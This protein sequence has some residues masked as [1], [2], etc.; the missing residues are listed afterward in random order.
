[1]YPLVSGGNAAIK[2]DSESIDSASFCAE[3]SLDPT[4]VK[5]KLVFC[6]IMNWGADSV[7][8]SVGGSGVIIQSD[9]FLD[10]S[11]IFMAPATMVGSYV[12][13]NIDNYIHSTR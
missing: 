1:M 8:K 2:N 7:V 11:D 9:Q 4:K 10:G 5:G 3:G 13:A 12:G 6:K